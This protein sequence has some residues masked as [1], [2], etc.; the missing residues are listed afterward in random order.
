M[1]LTQLSR[2]QAEAN[3]KTRQ[4]GTLRRGCLQYST[5][6][7]NR[8]GHKSQPLVTAC[9]SKSDKAACKACTESHATMLSGIKL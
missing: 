5:R 8:S 2:T 4:M 9:L 6:Q 1:K 3:A 7:E